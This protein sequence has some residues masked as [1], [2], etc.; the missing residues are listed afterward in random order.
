MKLNKQIIGVLMAV[1]S[2]LLC[3][4]VQAQNTRI[5]EK[6]DI[7]W[8]NY[9]GTIAVAKKVS[10]HTEYQW[11]R[12]NLITNWQQSLLRLGVNYQV[13]PKLQLRLGY[14]WIETFAYGENPINGLG[15]DFTEH[16]IFQVATITDKIGKVDLSHRFML[17]QRFVG[18]YTT[19]AVTKEDEFL[20]L[21]RLRYMYR[22]QVPLKGKSIGNNTPYAAVYDEV[23]VGFGKNVNQN[24]F[25]QNRLGILLGYKFNNNVRIE[26]GYLN[27]ILQLG[28]QVGGR[29]VFQYNNGL[30]IN[31][32][33]NFS[34][35]KK[36]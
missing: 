17:E 16:R 32:N 12:D 33:F 20:F 35:L 23:F 7:G 3:H 21:N 1:S 4:T 36:K 24:V 29:N 8:Y 26:G 14:G 28:R 6:N 30:I 22:M 2:T 5:T 18:R 10:I 31:A 13:N 9:F 25:D 15:R 19:P 27:Q 34:L 11:R